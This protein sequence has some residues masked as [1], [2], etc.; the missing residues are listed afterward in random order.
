M[1]NV[2]RKHAGSW[3]IKVILF[4]IVIVFVFWGVGSFRSREASKVASVNDQ[5]IS[6]SD[7]RRVYNNLIDQYRQRFGDSLNDGMIEM[8]QL[9]K[10]AMDQLITRAILLQEAEKLKLRVSDD[11]I[12]ESIMNTSVFQNNGT[13]DNRRYR[14]LLAQVHLTP[15][16]YEADQKK[17]LLGQKLTRVIMGAAKVSEA[18]V[19]QWYDWQNAKVD[20]DYILIDPDQYTD[21]KSSD[22]EI[23]AY[24][25]ENKENYKTDPMVGTRYVVFDPKDLV[26]Q[27]S[28]EEDEIADYYDANIDE[29]QTEKTVEARHILIKLDEEA[30]EEAVAAAKARAEEIAEMAKGGQDFAELAKVHSEGPSKDQGGYL[31]KFQQGQMVKPFSDKAFSMSA[32]EI[33][34]PVKTRFGWHVIKVESVDEASTRSIEESKEVIVTKLTDNKALSLAYDNAE[35]FY[36]G[37]FEKDDLANNAKSFGLDVVETEPFNRNGP[38]SLGPQKGEFANAALA[39]D[40][41]EISDIQDLGGRYYLIQVTEKIDAKIPDLKTVKAEVETDLIEKM[42]SDKAKADAESLAEELRTGKPFDE[43]ASAFDKTVKNTGLFGRSGAIPE[44]GSDQQF[45]QAAFQL[46]TASDTSSQPVRGNDGFYLLHMKSRKAPEESGFETE[47]EKIE[48]MLLQQKQ[49]GLFTD[50][51]EARKKESQIS[52]EEAFLE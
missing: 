49:A 27:V 35:K 47:K 43:V 41:D 2:M 30:D 32:G 11:E 13:F 42:K 8:L 6:L 15:E 24:F 23:A 46:T 16:E 21:I 52:I 17:V 3:M 33:S 36:E 12:A 20:I 44:I 31:G 10:Q 38:D 28:V 40:V 34:E 25:D 19:R 48:G 22:D 1:L 26:D 14:S 29:F 39:L 7:Y 51:I 18:E 4:A 45:S 50:W 9:D 37:S 5:I